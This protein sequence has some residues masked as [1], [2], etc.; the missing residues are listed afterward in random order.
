MQ[1]EKSILS[2]VIQALVY[3][4]LLTVGQAQSEPKY[5]AKVPESVK[6]PDVVETSTLVKLKFFDGMPSK[7]TVEKLYDNLDLARAVTAF[8]D[9]IPIASI[10]G[11]VNGLP[12]VGVQPNEIG[13]TETLQDARSIWLTCNT[14]TIYITSVVDTTDGPVVIHVPPGILALL[15]DAAFQYVGD[16]GPLGP[17]KGKGGKYLLLPPGY[18]G[19]VPDGYFVLESKSYAHWFLGRLS[20]DE[21]GETESVVAEFKKVM[22]IYPLSEAANPPKEKFVNLSGLQYNTVHANNFEFFEEINQAVQREP[23]TAFSPELV[24]VF[25]S[26]GIRKGE[27]FEPDARLK[28]I[29]AEAAAIGNA[30]ARAITYASR[31]PKVYFYEDRQW[32]SPFQRQSYEFLVDDVRMLDDRSYFHYMATGIT[33]AMTSP[34]VGSGSVYCMTARDKDGEYLDGGKNYKVVLPAPIP[35][36]NFWS[37]MAYSGQ[38]RS[39]LETD[40]KSGGLDSKRP[41]LVS[42]EDGSVTVWLGPEAPKGKEGNW[43]QTMP[44]KSYNMMFR[45]YGPLEPWFDKSWRPGDFELTD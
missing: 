2:S 24:G 7:E 29:L 31:D 11:F 40:Q 36:K 44:G 19:E 20:P 42:N 45:L 15:D 8:L 14:T 5:A 9:G 25:H 10:Q 3:V 26:I 30:T 27:P 12:E 21:N 38:T 41:D 28:T 18:E 23:A 22:N 13:I 6:T 16:F 34:P 4:L 37:F 33:P 39:I 1:I 17:D 32:N 35:A 43:I